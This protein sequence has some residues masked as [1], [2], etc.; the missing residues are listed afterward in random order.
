MVIFNSYV[1]LPEGISLVVPTFLP[2]PAAGSDYEDL[3]PCCSQTNSWAATGISFDQ[4]GNT[5]KDGTTGTASGGGGDLAIFQ[6]GA[7][8]EVCR[9]FE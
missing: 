2:P 1:K 7:G 3:K 6:V 9:W 8:T 4:S 5:G